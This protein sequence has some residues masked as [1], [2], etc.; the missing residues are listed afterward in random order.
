MPA[1][2]RYGAAEIFGRTIQ[3]MTTSALRQ[4][5]SADHKTISCP[6]KS[7]GTPYHKKGGV[8]PL[9]QFEK[10]VVGAVN[11]SAKPV[12]MCPTRFYEAGIVH[13]WVG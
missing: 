3:Q 6:Y 4:A 12:T 13:S 11:I 7:K 2:M 10:E 5:A 9:V 1:T 8:C